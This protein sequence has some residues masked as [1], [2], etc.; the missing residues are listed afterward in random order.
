MRDLHPSACC[1]AEPV[2]ADKMFVEFSHNRNRSS[3]GGVHVTLPGQLVVA[4]QPC[5][6]F[7]ESE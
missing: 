5:I 6:C 2:Y 4:N 1:P 7:A 3:F